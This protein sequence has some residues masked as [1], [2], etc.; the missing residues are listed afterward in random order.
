M[1]TS[2]S[3]YIA[4][5]TTREGRL[6]PVPCKDLF[7]LLTRDL[8]SPVPSR[9]PWGALRFSVAA[10]CRRGR[11]AHSGEFLNFGHP[12]VKRAKERN[13]SAVEPRGPIKIGRGSAVAAVSITPPPQAFVPV[14]GSVEEDS[15]TLSRPC[16]PGWTTDAGR[17]QLRMYVSVQVLLD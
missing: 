14:G 16:W 4:E 3:I 7:L 15:T 8:C 17:Q 6:S 9:V 13:Q 11:T 1:W 12:A 2:S 5:V 10:F